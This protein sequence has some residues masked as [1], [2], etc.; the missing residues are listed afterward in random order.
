LAHVKSLSLPLAILL[1]IATPVRS[2]PAEQTLLYIR[3]Q[4]SNELYYY[5]RLVGC[6]WA[7]DPIRPEWKMYSKS[8]PD[9]TP[10]L[11]PLSLFEPPV[12]G[13]NFTR[14]STTRLLWHIGLASEVV[15][16]SQLSEQDGRCAVT[17]TTMIDS[18][19]L[20]MKLAYVRDAGGVII[21]T[22]Y[23][24][25]FPCDGDKSPYQGFVATV[26]F[27][28][29]FNIKVKSFDKL[30]AEKADK[31]NIDPNSVCTTMAK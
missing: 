1:A 10:T 27:I 19:P 5:A 23:L 31:G 28:N 2:E 7:E 29:P 8:K 12:Y 18:K 21:R 13:P 30:A 22:I 16:T 15:F 17:T 9:G 20:P 25:V 6:R 24:T 26:S 14:E 3:N 4:N 11:E